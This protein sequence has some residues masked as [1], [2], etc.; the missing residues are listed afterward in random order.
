[1]SIK[2]FNERV[3]L[4]NL[5]AQTFFDK[6]K[7]SNKLGLEYLHPGFTVRPL[8]NKY[9]NNIGRNFHDFAYD[10][11]Y[12]YAVAV[13]FPGIVYKIDPETVSIVTTLTL[14]ND[15][16]HNGS[17]GIVYA[18]GYLWVTNQDPNWSVTKIDPVTMTEVANILIAEGS[19]HYG[20]TDGTNVYFVTR[21]SPSVLIV[22]DPTT[23]T[24]TTHTLAAGFNNARTVIYELGYLW[25][26]SE[27]SPSI[28]DRITVDTWAETT[29]TL[30]VT[31]LGGNCG[32][33]YHL[34]SDGNNIFVVTARAAAP[35]PPTIYKISPANTFVKST[36]LPWAEFE[37]EP[38]Y[39]CFDGKYLYHIFHRVPG[40]LIRVNPDELT[41]EAL[42]FPAGDD[43]PHCCIY[44]GKRVWVGFDVNPGVLRGLVFG[45]STPIVFDA[46]VTDTFPIDAVALNTI[47]VTFSHPFDRTPF[48]LVCLQDLTATDAVFDLVDV[49]SITTT[50]CTLR[51]DISTASVTGG[52]TGRF[53]WIAI[54]K[55]LGAMI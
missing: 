17:Y 43:N 25:S 20:C 26:G 28:I 19:C 33:I 21:T 3:R 29:L 30:P 39:W 52:A 14:P 51:A 22:I 5:H 41:W 49:S 12:L 24:Y 46:G 55:D 38:H 18:F 34:V 42:T 37:G 45:P 40:K 23:D 27:T 47:N 8:D 31:P 53:S 13:T 48:V 4:R 54:A 11:V 9:N 36:A 32:Y 2:C 7:L 50:G 16:N 6:K 10:G 35:Q 15:G 44:T 1:M